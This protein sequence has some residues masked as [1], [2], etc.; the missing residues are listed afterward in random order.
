MALCKD[1]LLDPGKS[2]YDGF[3]Y[4]R[5]SVIF[6]KSKGV[7]RIRIHLTPFAGCL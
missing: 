7:E 1:E 4:V 6:F 5:L 3:K 2:H